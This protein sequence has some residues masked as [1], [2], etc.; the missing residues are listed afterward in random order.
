MK[1][2]LLIS[3]LLMFLTSC[4]HYNIPDVVENNKTDKHILVPGT[5]LYLIPSNEIDLENS[6][7]KLSN[8][9]NIKLSI[10]DIINENFFSYSSGISKE[11]AEANKTKVI[12]FKKF[13]IGSYN[14]KILIVQKNDVKERAYTLIFGDTTFCSSL[15]C[16]YPANNEKLENEIIKT[17]LTVVYDKNMKGY[18]FQYSRFTVDIDSTDFRYLKEL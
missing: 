10:K 14:A 4:Q 8:S 5:R 9:S 16:V 15:F 6:Y 1:D 17:S 18:P 11:F 12:F 3:I 2:Y 7:I 13:F